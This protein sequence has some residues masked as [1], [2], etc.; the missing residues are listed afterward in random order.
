MKTSAKISQVDAWLGMRLGWVVGFASN[1]VGKDETLA[2]P[3]YSS[4]IFFNARQLLN[5]L[6]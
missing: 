4:A 1:V 6:F 3:R 2:Y 5:L